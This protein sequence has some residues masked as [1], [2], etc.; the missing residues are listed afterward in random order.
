MDSLPPLHVTVDS[1][2]WSCV[3]DLRLALS[4][5][6]PMLALRLC[7]E[8]RICLVP[9]LWYVLD[10]SE[11]YRERLPSWLRDPHS[12]EGA[13]LPHPDALQQWER[14]RVELGL[15]LLRLFWAGDALHESSL[16]KD[17]DSR[18]IERFERLARGLERRASARAS[19]ATDSP[20]V[21]GGLDAAA[22][23]AAL[24]RYRPLIFTSAGANGAPPPLCRLLEAAGVPCRQLEPRESEPVRRPLL[25]VF[26]RSGA[27]E[28][29]WAG[30]GLSLV[31]LVV[32]RAFIPFDAAGESFDGGEPSCDTDGQALWESSSAYWYSLP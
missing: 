4:L 21:A 17:V 32:P 5:H 9:R 24:G 29:C 1:K 20:L 16:P 28:L 31:H 19:G 2:T 23:A 3:L 15:S 26:A 25:G 30:L 18:V 7:E 14:A 6:G 12:D 10:H 13:P 8:L 11:H 27:L 22:L